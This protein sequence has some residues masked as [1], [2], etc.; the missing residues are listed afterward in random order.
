MG[1]MPTA[2]APNAARVRASQPGSA[3]SASSAWNPLEVRGRLASGMDGVALAHKGG[4]LHLNQV[5]GLRCWC[6]IRKCAEAC[7]APA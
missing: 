7:S 3:S 6:Y 4:L 1:P 5:R 2:A